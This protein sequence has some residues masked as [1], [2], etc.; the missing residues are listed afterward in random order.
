MSADDEDASL[1]RRAAAG[2]TAAFGQLMR[3]HKEPL[4]RLVRRITG[5]PDEAYDLVQ[6]SFVALWGSIARYDPARPFAAW[7]RRIALNKC[8]DW[9]RRRQVRRWA[10]AIVPGF[11]A[12]DTV[13]DP[14]PSPEAIAGDRRTLARVDAALAA[15]PAKLKEP[16][17]LTVF[18][19]YSQA[20]TAAL[21][22]ISRKAV[23]TR[24]R[25]AR[26]R[27]TLALG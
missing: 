2:D 10:A 11:D 19:G 1:A 24:V 16:L 21:L 12:A 4:Y 15:L 27:L 5:D 22:G 8:R 20:E 23:E 13:P 25:R 18:G 3:R 17:V 9:A 26:D 7:A 6:E 14:V